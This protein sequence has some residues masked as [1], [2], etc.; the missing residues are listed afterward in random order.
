MATQPDEYK[1]PHEIEDDKGKPES[2]IEITYEEDTDEVKVEIK[3]DTPAADRNVD[4]LPDDVKDSLEKADSS[5]EYSH[6]FKTKFKQYK[7]AW[8][9]ERRAKESAL[10]EQNEALGIAQRI[11]DENN[12][13]KHMLQKA[14]TELIDKYKY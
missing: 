2:D 10:R 12:R 14:E 9:D 4:P 8:H 1:F 5:E 6:N 7:K 3:D 13:L 11:L